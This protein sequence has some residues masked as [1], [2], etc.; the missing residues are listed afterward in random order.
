VLRRLSS[1]QNTKLR[2]LAARVV[3]TRTLPVAR[4]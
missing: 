1:Q 4:D 3:A 2:D